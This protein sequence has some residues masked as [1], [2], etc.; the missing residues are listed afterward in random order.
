LQWGCPRFKMCLIC[1]EILRRRKQLSQRPR[2]TEFYG[3]QSC[4]NERRHQRARLASRYRGPGDPKEKVEEEE[5]AKCSL[6][7]KNRVAYPLMCCLARLYELGSAAAS[8]GSGP[9]CHHE[10]LELLLRRRIANSQLARVGRWTD[11]G[12]G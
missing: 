3:P 6:A 12:Q 9:C 11:G 5:A 2:N 7:S 1:K 4:P 8:A 10:A